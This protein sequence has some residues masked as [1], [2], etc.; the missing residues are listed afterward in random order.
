[1]LWL[2]LPGIASAADALRPVVV[3]DAFE[4]LDLASALAVCPE[5]V[6]DPQGED[7]RCRSG[8]PESVRATQEMRLYRV[9]LWAFLRVTNASAKERVFVLEHH[10]AITGIITLQDLSVG[11]APVKSAG[12]AV[13]IR[14]RD[15][16]AALPVFKIVLQPK[17]TKLFRISIASDIVTRPGFTLYSQ[18]RFFIEQ[19][20]GNLVHAFYYGLMLSMIFYNILLYLR[21]RS[22]MYLKYIFFILSLTVMYAG[23]Y[24]HGYA[25]IWQDWTSW[26]KY[27]HSVAKFTAAIFGIGFFSA[28]LNVKTRMPRLYRMVKP[29]Y[30]LIAVAALATPALSAQGVFL[31]ATIVVAVAV[32]YSLAL[33]I[34]SVIG[35]LPFSIYYAIAMTSML[36]GALINLLQTAAILPSNTFTIHAMQVGTALETIFLSIALGDRYEAIENENRAL[37][38][39][40][41]EDKKRIA[42]DIHDV[43]GTEFQMR[44]IEISSDGESALSLRVS[45]GLRSTMN[46]IREFLFLLHTDE[47]LPSNLEPNIRAIVAR[48]EATKKYQIDSHISVMPGVL[49]SADAYHLERA[50]DEIVSN[51]ARHAQASAV[52][53]RLCVREKR[54][55]LAVN[56][57]GVGFDI[58]L[59][60]KNIG[61]ESLKYR[62]ERLGGRLRL[63]TKPGA[64]TT[65][66]IRFKT[67]R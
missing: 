31:I 48:L 45:E 55:F 22:G 29:A 41:L 14:S 11:A 19:Q 17:E 20:R 28:V 7:A 61:L 6:Q 52:R 47:N 4:Q 66:A 8:K 56:D 60:V 24:G 12:E 25:F 51:L 27:S 59:V 58:G 38:L 40:R 23:L 49:H 65:V 15:Y 32:I 3:D 5:D 37:Q 34:L 2:I 30:A 53:F 9:P 33:G 57:N 67:Q 42:R 39:Q 21:L 13:S 44:L 54:G 63:V 36:T 35:K 26:Q 43:V 46:K 1:M 64:G 10:L 16:I 18:D 50:V 62:A